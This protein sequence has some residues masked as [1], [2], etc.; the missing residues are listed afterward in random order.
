MNERANEKM[1]TGWDGHFFLSRS[2]SLRRESYLKVVGLA[3]HDYDSLG[4]SRLP[5][6]LR[7]IL[8]KPPKKA[9]IC[10]ID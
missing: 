2:A 7:T 10:V 3:K 5:F 8:P 1:M 6:K 4:C 9:H